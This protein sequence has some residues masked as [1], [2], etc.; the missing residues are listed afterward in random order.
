MSWSIE[1]KIDYLQGQVHALTAFAQAALKT[2]E[3]PNDL[4]KVF[5]E[6]IL[7]NDANVLPTPMSDAWLSGQRAVQA[8]L[9]PAGTNPAER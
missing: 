1:E 5:E 8:L 4:L 6:Q 3:D 7:K 9:Y 2:H